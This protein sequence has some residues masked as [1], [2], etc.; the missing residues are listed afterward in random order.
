M[1]YKLN[2]ID[3]ELRQRVNEAT[4]DGKIHSKQNLIINKDKKDKKDKKDNSGQREKF[5]SMLEKYD[6][7][8]KKLTINA[9]K[10]QSGDVEV[11][12]D[13]EQSDDTSCGIF[14]DVRK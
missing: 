13:E 8:G 2:K 7:K 9:F 10:S 14:I 5:K 11:Y 1:E 6:G 4:K 12:R 3:T